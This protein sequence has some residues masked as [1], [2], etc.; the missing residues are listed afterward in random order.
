LVE[1]FLRAKAKYSFTFMREVI[2]VFS[3]PA[4]AAEVRRR[5][6]PS[7]SAGSHNS[8]AALSYLT[9]CNS[10]LERVCGRDGVV[11]EMVPPL[12]FLGQ[13]GALAVVPL[14]PFRTIARICK[15]DRNTGFM[16]AIAQP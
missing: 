4:Y 12:Y 9:P 3:A 16:P 1:S 13:R 5:K 7:Y 8:P 15:R 6:L 14:P 2:H 10:R 11:L